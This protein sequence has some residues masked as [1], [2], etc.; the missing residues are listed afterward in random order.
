MAKPKVT[1][2]RLRV[3]A[4]YQG[5]PLSPC[6]FV[7]MMEVLSWM[8]NSAREA[9]KFEGFYFKEETKVG[10][11]THLLFTDDT[12]IFCDAD[13]NQVLNILATIACFQTVT[14][15]RINLDK[16]VMYTVGDVAERSFYAAILGCKWSRDPLK[17][18]GFP[19]GSKPND[20][21]IWDP[22]LEKFQSKRMGGGA[23]AYLTSKFVSVY[24]TRQSFTN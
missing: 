17:Y 24:P 23:D 22:I 19:V 4:N 11:V 1:S 3:S 5:D 2:R 12:L 8:L 20:P 15:L 18:L 14:G 6:L 7:M 9:G 13:H 16:S 10:E 21:A